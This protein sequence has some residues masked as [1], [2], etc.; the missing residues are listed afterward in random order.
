MIV[1]FKGIDCRALPN[2]LL[3]QLGNL[4][5]AL[6]WDPGWVLQIRVLFINHLNSISDSDRSIDPAWHVASYKE[7]T[8]FNIDLNNKLIQDSGTF[9]TK[10]PR[11]LLAL[12]NLT[13]EL[14]VTN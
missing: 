6:G 13:W 7:K 14:I 12:E 3:R 8:A 11:H 1:V 4:F 5:Q 9:V 2:Q 10:L